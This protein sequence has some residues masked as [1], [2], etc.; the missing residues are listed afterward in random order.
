MGRGGGYLNIWDN[1]NFTE[2]SGTLT[3]YAV[4]PVGERDFSS[5]YADEDY[6][7]HRA[8]ME[9]EDGGEDCEVLRLHFSLDES[10]SVYT[11]PAPPSDDD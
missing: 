9:A 7:A 8:T 1:G 4:V 10:E 3:V 6:A 11:A 2:S 5:I